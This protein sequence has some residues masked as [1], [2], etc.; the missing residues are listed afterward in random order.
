MLDLIIKNGSCYID[1]NLK[2]VD[3]GIVCL[4]P[5]F[6]LSIIEL[7]LSTLNSICSEKL[8]VELIIFNPLSELP[9]EPFVNSILP[10]TIF[11]STFC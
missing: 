6:D 7:I 3:I 11:L 1:N 10:V 8:F 4:P 5:I 2:D 9:T